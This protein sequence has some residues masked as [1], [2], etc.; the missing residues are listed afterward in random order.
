MKE[1]DYDTYIEGYAIKNISMSHDVF[2]FHVEEDIE[3]PGDGSDIHGRLVGYFHEANED[4]RWF[5][6]S[7]T[8]MDKVHAAWSVFPDERIISVTFNGGVWTTSGDQNDHTQALNIPWEVMF[9]KNVRCIA[10]GKAYAVGGNR[11]VFRRDAHE[12]WVRMGKG[13]RYRTKDN[14]YGYN[15]KKEP[16]PT[17]E[18]IDGFSDNDLYVCGEGGDLWH[19]NGEYWRSLEPPTNLRFTSIC[20]AGDGYVYVVGLQGTILRGKGDAW[21]KIDQEIDDSGFLAVRWFK[22]K[23]Y[24]CSWYVLYTLEDDKLIRL[25][26]PEMALSDYGYLEANDDYLL[27][28]GPFSAASFDGERWRNIINEG[29][30]VD[31]NLET[32]QDLQDLKKMADV[33]E[34]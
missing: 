28:A 20:C 4:D 3:H 19:Y 10:Q 12:Q 30:D 1:K 9:I 14:D 2:T 16:A 13:L 24:I 5:S 29:I 22:G 18:D 8:N 25:D 15:K 11:S 27:A 17:F 31:K 33:R 7:T 23:V 6:V 32:L 26:I 34:S 21:E